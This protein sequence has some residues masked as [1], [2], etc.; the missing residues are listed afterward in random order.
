[1][2]WAKEGKNLSI[3]ELT[4]TFRKQITLCERLANDRNNPE[5][6]TAASIVYQDEVKAK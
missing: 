5:F 6:I 2:W 4:K 1:M 3:D